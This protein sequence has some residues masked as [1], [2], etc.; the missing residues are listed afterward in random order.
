M[1]PIAIGPIG[2]IVY[3]NCHLDPKRMMRNDLSYNMSF[4]V[5]DS[6]FDST[7]M[8]DKNDST[9]I[10]IGYNNNDSIVF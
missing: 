1:I 8:I 7:T 5:N 6:S 3:Y 10:L 4:I 9:A 2:I